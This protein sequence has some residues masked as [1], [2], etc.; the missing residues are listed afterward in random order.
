VKISIMNLNGAILV[1]GMNANV[2][3]HKP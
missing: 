1:P 3:I 2:R